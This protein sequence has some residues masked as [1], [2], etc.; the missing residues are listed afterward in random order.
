E[1]LA[2]FQAK[3]QRLHG[4][5]RDQHAI[6]GLGRRLAN[7]ICHTARLSPFAM[8]GK[9][10]LEGATKVVAAIRECGDEGLAYDRTRVSM[11]GAKDRGATWGGGRAGGAGGRGVPAR[12]ARCA[13]MSCAPS[14]TPAT[15][16]T[17]APPARPAARSSPT[18]RPASS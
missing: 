6:A 18:T 16:S 13:V 11:T 4:F 7:E 12:R 5:L 17:T 1:M 8:T 10:G 9:L 2:L 3:N 15:P 14:N